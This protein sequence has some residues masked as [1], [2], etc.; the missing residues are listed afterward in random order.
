MATAN[1]RAESFRSQR[2]REKRCNVFWRA[3]AGQARVWY[4]PQT[5]GTR[6]GRF[7]GEG[8]GSGRQKARNRPL[9]QDAATAEQKRTV[10][11]W[12]RCAKMQQRYNAGVRT[13]QTIA[14]ST[15]LFRKLQQLARQRRVNIDSIIE[16]AIIAGIRA[17]ERDHDGEPKQTSP[18][19]A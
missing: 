16:P 15:P 18:A 10:A 19:A 5:S 7:C 4:P 8:I 9:L 17:M 13:L 11:C 2:R 1:R 6:C 14:V 3:F 12:A